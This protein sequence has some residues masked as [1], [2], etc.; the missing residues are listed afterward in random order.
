MSNALDP[1]DIVAIMGGVV[2]GRD[3]CSVPGHG[4]S[5]ADRSLSIRIDPTRP[6][7]VEFN[8]FSSDN[9]RDCQDYIAAALDLKYQASRKGV[10]DVPPRRT[11][12]DGRSRPSEFP[13]RLW[14][15]AGS[16]R[17]TLAEKYLMSRQ[18]ALPD[19]QCCGFILRAHWGVFAIP[20]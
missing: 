10:I 6:L 18:L 7:G 8:S 13:L 5:R 16:A 14:S 11:G 3:S 9:P 12:Q 19:R 2:T 1:R 15:E 17:G 4:H 20:A